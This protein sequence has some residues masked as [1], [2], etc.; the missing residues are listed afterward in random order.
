M[1]PE[2][3]RHRPVRDAMT[4]HPLISRH[5]GFSLIELMVS[6]TIGLVVLAALATVFA[7][8]SA[9]RAELDRSS[10]Q[11]DNGRYAVDLLTEDLQIAGYFGE[12]NVTSLV[13][14]GAMPDVCSTTPADW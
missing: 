12:L 13:V 1:S 5:A 4:S 9:A 8:T 2:R 3:R 6:T 14:P 7:N 11:I 10:Q